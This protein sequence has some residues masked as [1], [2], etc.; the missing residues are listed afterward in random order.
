MTIEERDMLTVVSDAHDR[1]KGSMVRWL[2][3]V[4]YTALPVGDCTSI[5][6]K[7]CVNE[8]TIVSKSAAA[9]GAGVTGMDS[10]PKTPDPDPEKKKKK[11][12]RKRGGSGGGRV[13]QSRLLDMDPEPVAEPAVRE[14]I[15]HIN[16]TC[17]TELVPT[18]EE[19]RRLVNTRLAKSSIDDMKLVHE[20]ASD[21]WAD[22]KD[23]SG[24]NWREVMA[25]PSVLY[26]SKFGEHLSN[27]KRWKKREEAE[28]EIDPGA[29]P[30]D[31]ML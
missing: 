26:G 12:K 31:Q 21:R 24:T 27:A 20:W 8:T 17:G 30:A 23:N 14:V 16:S 9:L 10:A 5:V 3:R 15:E 6:S 4:A 25:V 18:D 11:D 22:E 19:V 1:D 28:A 29:P 2:I 7:S 13:S